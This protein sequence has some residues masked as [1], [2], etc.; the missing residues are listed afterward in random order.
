MI[1]GKNFLVSSVTILKIEIVYYFKCL[2]VETGASPKAQLVRTQMALQE[3]Q[4]T[5]VRSLGR[6]GPLE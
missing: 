3:T 4:E 2:S 5:Q 6:E 1:L